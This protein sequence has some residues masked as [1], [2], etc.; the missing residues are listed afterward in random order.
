M[1]EFVEPIYDDS[2]QYQWFLFSD[3]VLCRSLAV[4]VVNTTVGGDGIEASWFRGL[5]GL[6]GSGR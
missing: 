5:A 2:S 6:S 1:G 4:E 3:I